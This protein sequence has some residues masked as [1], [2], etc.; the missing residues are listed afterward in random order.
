[1]F[2][3][4]AIDLVAGASGPDLDLRSIGLDVL[5]IHDIAARRAAIEVL[6]SRL[7]YLVPTERDALLARVMDIAG[8][9]S[10]P[11]DL[12]LTTSQLRALAE[13]GVEIGGHTVAHTILSTLDDASA[14]SEILRGKRQLEEITGKA[15]KVFAYPNGG[16]RKDYTSAHVAMMRELGFDVAV[17]TAYG[18][19]NMRSDPYQ[20]PRF[21][22][23]GSS[24]AKWSVQLVR[25]ALLKRP[26]SAC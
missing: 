8:G 17:T 11:T 7:K 2:N 13:R 9:H 12:M 5:P 18:V 20:L 3:D 14:R 6:L 15:V 25:N 21:T 24:M 22:P 4:A 10:L 26:A 23:W 19:G 1:M 16:P